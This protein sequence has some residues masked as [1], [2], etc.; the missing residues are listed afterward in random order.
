VGDVVIYESTVY[1]GATEEDCVP[2]LEHFSGLK[3]NQDFSAGYSP[4]RVNPG[5]KL[6]R[7]ADIKK[8]T[9][10]S[11]AEIADLVDSLYKE[12][13]VTRHMSVII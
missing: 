9:S 12:I 5:D 2:I 7:V 6:H 3:F 1:P 11:T 8:V 4:E 10:G 13:I